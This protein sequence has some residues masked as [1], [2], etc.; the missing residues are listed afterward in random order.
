MV[1]ADEHNLE[2]WAFCQSPADELIEPLLRWNGR[3]NRVVHVASDDQRISAQVGQLTG[4]PVEERVMLDTTIESIKLLAKM[5]VRRMDYT[6]RPH[7]LCKC[8]FYCMYDVMILTFSGAGCAIA[9][10][11]ATGQIRDYHKEEN[12]PS[13]R[14]HLKTWRLPLYVR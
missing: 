11:G 4:Q 13:Q 14:L 2:Q 5:P 9:L 1:A 8:A 3:I 7:L 6:H 12:D 10:L